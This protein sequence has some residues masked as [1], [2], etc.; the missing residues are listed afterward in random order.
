[1]WRWSIC[2]FRLVPAV[3]AHPFSGGPGRSYKN[4]QQQHAYETNRRKKRR[5]RTLSIG[6]PS[7]HTS[8]LSPVDNSAPLVSE[9]CVLCPIRVRY[10][11]YYSAAGSDT[12]AGTATAPGGASGLI[13]A[14][15]IQRLIAAAG[16]DSR[17]RW[18][19][20]ESPHRVFVAIETAPVNTVSAQERER[21]RLYVCTQRCWP[22]SH[23]LMVVSE[24]P[25]MHC[26]H[27]N[28]TT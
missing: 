18:V 5:T 14:C 8:R 1:M 19:H 2:C 9:K 28:A 20:S 12:S 26:I 15:T 27:I 4:I 3:P 11:I 13:R 21:E 16:E 23:T 25:D 17:E 22:R 6:S 7:V 24:L 10:Q